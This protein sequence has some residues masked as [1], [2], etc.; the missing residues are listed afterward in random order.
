[1]FVADNGSN[2][3]REYTLST[4]FDISTASYDSIFSVH[5]QDTKPSGVAFNRDGTKMFVLGGVG[6]DVIE[7]HLTTGFDISTASYD[8]NFS[9]A[10][11]DNEPVGLAFNSD[12]TKMFVV[13]ARDKDVNEYTLSTGFDV[14]TASYTRNFIVSGHDTAPKGLAFSPDGRKMFVTGDTGDEIIEYTLSTGFKVDTASIVGRFD[15]SSQGTQ[16][17]GITFNNDG[18]KMFITD[19]SGSLGQHSVDEIYAYHSFQFS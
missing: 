11:Q 18:T 3:I 8:S 12:G 14:S 9:V 4:A 6:N 5:L 16:P 15:V 2:A 1:M 13:G 19:A 10:S 7:Y 17:T